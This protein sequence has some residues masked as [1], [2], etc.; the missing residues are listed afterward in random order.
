MEFD[1]MR[2]IW[3]EQK[4]ETMYAINEAALHKIVTK[5]KN[6]AS[7]R[8][9]RVE[10]FLS[11]I[12][13]LAG[14]FLLIRSLMYPHV[15]G[16][17]NAGVIIATIPFIQYFRWKRRKAENTFDRSIMGELDHAIANT[18][19]IIKFHY[20]MIV[21]Y[22]VPISVVCISALIIAE[23]SLVKWLIV[24]GALALS[25]LAIRWEQRRCNVPWRNQLLA[26][27]AKLME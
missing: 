14:T 9:S 23:A 25:I 6:A 16:F 13:G 20:L 8:I 12:N 11:I 5:K 18:N 4:G 26:L 3:D 24:T 27:K 1:E 10:I 22:L 7:K 17:I 2:K 19:S 21:G 15:L